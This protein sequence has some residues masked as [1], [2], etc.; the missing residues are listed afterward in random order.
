MEYS[1]YLSSVQANF[2]EEE[3]VIIN[4]CDVKMFRETKFNM[5]WLAT[6]LKMF[7]FI[8]HF[9]NVTLNDISQYSDACMKYSLNAYKGFPR[10]LQNGVVCFGLIASENVDADAAAFAKM[11]PKKHFAAFEMPIIFDLS[12]SSIHYFEKT[13]MLGAIYYKFI[14]EYIEKN[15]SV[16]RDTESAAADQPRSE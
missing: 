4:G 7:S 9:D 13:P 11:R 10:G 15:F 3:N 12:D 8:T 1:E 2:T 16:L 14:R 5:K 6:K